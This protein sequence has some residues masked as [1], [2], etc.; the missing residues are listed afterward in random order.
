MRRAPKQAILMT[1]ILGSACAS[2]KASVHQYATDLDLVLSAV[3]QCADSVGAACHDLDGPSPWAMEVHGVPDDKS[4]IVQASME[5]ALLA[6]GL[7][8][9]EYASEMDSLHC[10]LQIRVLDLGMRYKEI[11][12]R[13]F[14][15]APWVQREGRCLLAVRC[16][17]PE[18]SILYSGRLD[19]AAAAWAPGHMVA[20]LADP[21][22]APTGRPVPTSS[23]IVG[24]LAVAGAAAGLLALFFITSE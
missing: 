6:R 22:I 9:D 14:S 16:I 19:G 17:A 12:R 18:G 11:D 23:G 7:S 4:W 8:L 10:R 15:R 13:G 21:S 1:I 3:A 2:H 24:A 5:R 20:A